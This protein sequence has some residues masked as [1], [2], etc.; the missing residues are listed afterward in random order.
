MHPLTQPFHP[1]PV[2]V[3]G[4]LWPNSIIEPGT[5][6]LHTPVTLRR[7]HMRHVAGVPV[8]EEVASH[9]REDTTRQVSSP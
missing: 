9:G 4:P 6:T 5:S 3:C 8:V 2:Q 1:V 7:Y